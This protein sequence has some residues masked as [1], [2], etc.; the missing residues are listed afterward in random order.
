MIKMVIIVVLK[1]NSR[2]NSGQ[3]LSHRSIESTRVNKRIKMVVIV[4]LKSTQGLIG[5]QDERQDLSHRSI[6]STRVNIRIKIVVIVVVKSTQGLIGSQ[7]ERVNQICFFFKNQSNLVL[8]KT[9]QEKSTGFLLVFYPEF[10]IGSSDVN[11]S[12]IFFKVDQSKPR[13]SQVLGQPVKLVQVL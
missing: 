2:V 8:P 3:D 12:S 4:V 6:G 1:L 7:D 11:S 5:S 10:L 13:V 9:I